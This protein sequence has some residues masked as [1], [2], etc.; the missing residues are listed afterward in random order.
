MR[1]QG[2]LW[3]LTGFWFGCL[4]VGA[5]G[6][7][8]SFPIFPK[9]PRAYSGGYG[10]L[11]RTH[12]HSGWDIS[13]RGRENIPVYASGD[14]W[15]ERIKVSTKG[16]GYAVYVRHRDGKSTVYAH[17]NDFKQDVA[18]WV[19]T[20]QYLKKRFEV[21]LFPKQG[22]FSTERGS[23]LAL[24]GN[25]GRS[26]GPHLHFEARNK[27]N[28]AIHPRGLGFKRPDRTPPRLRKLAFR[29]RDAKARINGRFGRVEIEVKK[30]RR[31]RHRLDKVLSL[32]G[33]IG[34]EYFAYDP[35]RDTSG[36]GGIARAV[37]SV[38]GERVF[39]YRLGALDFS[40]Q[41]QVR[42]HAYAPSLLGR[43]RFAKLFVQD[44]NTL[45]FY[46]GK[47]WF[48]FL[49]NRRYVLRLVLW[50]DAGNKT[51][52]ESRV[53]H[54]R[55]FS[56]LPAQY[57]KG[58]SYAV[59]ENLLE[60]RFSAG[61][62]QEVTLHLTDQEGVRLPDYHLAAHDVYLW[63]LRQGLPHRISKGEQ[64]LRLHL[65]SVLPKEEKTLV[66]KDMKIHFPK[67]AAT[68]T[69]YLYVRRKVLSKGGEWFSV[70]N[71]E[72]VVQKEVR[73]TLNTQQT[74]IMPKAR[75]FRLQGRE[76]VPLSFAWKKRALS[77]ADDRL[78]T[79]LVLTDT[80]P[81]IVR[82]RRLNR[83]EISLLVRDDLSKID[84][85]EAS[86]NG[87][88][89]L[90]A[91]HPQKNRLFAVQKN[92]KDSFSGIFECLVY[93]GAGNVRAFAKHVP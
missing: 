32:K 57:G 71:R 70:M 26:S 53:N 54:K 58:I 24:S 11:R 13:T 39:A 33:W 5:Q 84:R 28:Q 47:G 44:G 80:L 51:T 4:R 27:N 73:I 61:Q 45:P 60:V 66:W 35:L 43:E 23:L 85:W 64:Q 56:P 16:Y 62:P 76:R 67:H 74:Y 18:A 90:M 36:R 29:T 63:D 52:L 89:L 19:V 69:S 93:D 92:K 65:Q 7:G 22:L 55:N 41:H 42:H 15:I 86:L 78:G 17:L 38:N 2:W 88:W 59:Q 30:G 72:A 81:P 40:Q 10:E 48:Y 46:E 34:L 91:Y 20:Q 31:G 37:L 68:D 75:L 6:S 50:D 14:G 82:P 21:D 79:Y 1:A 49:P 3:V 77:F 8:Y 83:R 25:T 87:E 12:F 9:G